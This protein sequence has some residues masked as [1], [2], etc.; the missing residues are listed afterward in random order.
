MSLI[1]NTNIASLGAQRQLSGSGMTLDRATERLSSGQRINSAK[2]DAAGLAIST[3]MTSQIKGLDQAVRNANDGVSL[4]QTAE[5]ALQESTNILQRMRELAVQSSNGIYSDGDRKTLNAEVKQ[6]TSELD[7]ISQTTSF[8]GKN[9]LDGTLGKVDLQVGASSNQTISFSIGAINSKNLGLGSTSGDVSSDRLVSALTIANGALKINGVGLSAFTGAANNTNL[10]TLITDINTKVADVTAS[11]FNVVTGT[12]VATGVTGS[13]GANDLVISLYDVKGGAKTDYSISNTTDV[14]SFIKQINEK[15]N[16]AVVASV[17]TSG[18]LVLS[19]TT[20]GAIE[21]AEAGTAAGASGI[22]DAV[23]QGELSLK[24]KTNSA[25][26]IEK[27]SVGTDTTLNDIG[28]RTSTGAGKL[29]GSAV[30]VADQDDGLRV[31]GLKINGTAVPATVHAAG[32]SS[33]QES[34]NSINSVTATTG[35]TAK[36]TSSTSFAADVSKTFAE[37]AMTGVPDFALL[38]VA[39][40]AHMQINGIDVTLTSTT[41]T[42]L[43]SA[44]NGAT[45]N[46][47]VSAYGDKNGF[48]HLVSSAP[49]TLAAATANNASAISIGAGG[50][51]AT[52]APAAASA[53]VGVGVL[54]GSIVLNGTEIDDLNL[55]SLDTVVTGLNAATATTGVTASIDT[56]GQLNLASNAA[57]T[58][59]V[60]DFNGLKTLA[61]LGVAPTTGF[62]TTAS[63]GTLA[64][65]AVGGI[66]PSLTLGAR[67]DLTSAAGRALSIDA[68]AA[69]QTATGLRN[70]NTDQSS[71]VT[72]SAISGLSV[73]TKAGAQAAITSIDQALDTISNTRSELGSVNNRLDFTVANLTSISEKTTAARSRIVDADF[74]AETANLSRSTVLQQAAQ[75]MLAQS[76]SRPQQVLSLLR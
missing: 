3:R 10:D 11:G 5:G 46:T 76:N 75:A 37:K 48:L 27:G 39:A 44:I 54:G 56:N 22:T 15:T 7:R 53:L 23:Y 19:N 47:G 61:A 59:G 67:L 55:T 52:T 1:I 38:A 14:A 33:L 30:L 65:A 43:T 51:F 29:L 25:I 12:A 20:G 49:I 21:T 58:V 66:S 4:I 34:A 70:Q 60:G 17:D 9:L 36:I 45:A 50:A 68:T 28:L 62:A 69:A 8:N 42:G 41:M 64:A 24:S 32:T 63:K 73:A 74:A 16:G 57:I 26:T 72:G 40:T 6:L 18:H 35:V 71:T 2:D 31:N 13:A